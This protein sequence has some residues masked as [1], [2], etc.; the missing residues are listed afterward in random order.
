MQTDSAVSE[1]KKKKKKNLCHVLGV[2]QIKQENQP[3]K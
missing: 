3:L 1:L 2:S